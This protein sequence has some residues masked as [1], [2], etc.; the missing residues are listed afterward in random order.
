MTNDEYIARLGELPPQHR[1]LAELLMERV[2]TVIVGN[3]NHY[4]DTQQRQ[5][6]QIAELRTRLDTLEHDINA[7]RHPPD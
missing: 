6:R 1:G 4:L 2:T 3:L 5:A 7:R